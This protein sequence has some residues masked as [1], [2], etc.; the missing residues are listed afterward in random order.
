MKVEKKSESYVLTAYLLFRFKQHSLINTIGRKKKAQE[1]TT[2]ICKSC[3]LGED[4]S[5]QVGARGR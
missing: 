5:L 2:R 4:V 3:I 1:R